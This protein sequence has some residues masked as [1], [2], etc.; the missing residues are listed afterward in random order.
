MKTTAFLDGINNGYALL[1]LG[2][3]EEETLDVKLSTLAQYISEPLKEGDVLEIILS[4]EQQVIGASKLVEETE[5]RHKEA[6][7]LTNRLMYGIYDDK[8]IYFYHISVIT[9]IF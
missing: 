3:D 2:E 6:V 9:S 8:E 7:A 1:L 4:N 5:R